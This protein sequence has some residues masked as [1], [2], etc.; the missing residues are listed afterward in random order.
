MRSNKKRKGFTLIELAIVLVIIGIILGAILKGQELI[1][2]A[3]AKRLQNDLRGLE[4]AVWTYYDRKSAFPGDCN[5]DGVI[6]Y[7]LTASPNLTTLSFT[8]ITS[9]PTQYCVIATTDED[10]PDRAFSDLRVSNI[11]NFNTLTTYLLNMFLVDI[12]Q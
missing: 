5:K 1:H 8:D 3:K 6:G 4:A 12:M 10:S 7:S 2:N 11:L 9:T